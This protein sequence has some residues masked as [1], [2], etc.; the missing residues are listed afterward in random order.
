MR[1]IIKE[2]VQGCSRVKDLRMH[3]TGV[4]AL[5]TAVEE[6]I[7]NFFQRAV[8]NMVHGGRVTL[9][10]SDFKLIKNQEFM[11][12]GTATASMRTVKNG[13]GAEADAYMGS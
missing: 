13:A 2:L 9:K 8:L 1:K 3:E 6:Y 7:V 5:H 11:E 12:R 10:S 4:A